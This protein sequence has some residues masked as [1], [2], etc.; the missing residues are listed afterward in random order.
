[1]AIISKILT[2][3]STDKLEK[4]VKTLTHGTQLN[5]AETRLN[6]ILGEAAAAAKDKQEVSWETVEVE[7]S[8]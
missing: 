1:M 6:D 4:R 7:S 5:R 2:F 3:E 8:E